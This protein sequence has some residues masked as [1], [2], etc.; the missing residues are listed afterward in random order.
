MLISTL[1]MTHVSVPGLEYFDY[2]D[3]KRGICLHAFLHWPRE[4]LCASLSC[5]FLMTCIATR[6][7]DYW[8]QKEGSNIM[9]FL[10]WVKV[11]FCL[12]LWINRFSIL[13]WF[14]FPFTIFQ[15][16]EMYKILIFIKKKV[17]KCNYRHFLMSWIID[18]K[19][20]TSF[21][22]KKTEKLSFIHL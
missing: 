21:F 15:T 19:A 3:R 14:F 11:Y 9:V 16:F 10:T 7:I 18:L 12:L 1:Q 4:K 13:N 8:L 2:K 17:L 20:K 22:S 5:P 6:I